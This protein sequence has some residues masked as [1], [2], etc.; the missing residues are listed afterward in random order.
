M[1]AEMNSLDIYI[2]VKFREI[3]RKISKIL[4]YRRNIADKWK[5]NLKFLLTDYRRDISCR[6]SPIHEI[7]TDISEIFNLGYKRRRKLIMSIYVI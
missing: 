6:H 5:K 3:S 2:S 1:T 4:I 7:S